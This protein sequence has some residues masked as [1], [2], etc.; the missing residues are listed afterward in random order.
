MQLMQVEA[1][2]PAVLHRQ[3]TDA[4]AEQADRS[5]LPVA[6][7]RVWSPLTV[8]AQAVEVA[9]RQS[10]RMPAMA[11]LAAAVTAAADATIFLAVLVV[12]GGAEKSAFSYSADPYPWTQE[13]NL[14][15]A[16]D[17]IGTY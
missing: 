15:G 13:N 10:A 7:D 14:V 9:V 3:F 17:A 2:V 8:G 11:V 5:E 6:R 12:W 1:Q 4:M 16:I